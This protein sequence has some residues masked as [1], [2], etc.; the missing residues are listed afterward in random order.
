MFLPFLFY[1][2]FFALG[3]VMNVLFSFK[4]HL[5]KFHQWNK[6]RIK[7]TITFAHFEAK[8]QMEVK[9]IGFRL[10]LF[11]KIII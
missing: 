8:K 10:T 1:I 9:F 5:V 4:F 2:F 11:D 3:I 6:I 7:L